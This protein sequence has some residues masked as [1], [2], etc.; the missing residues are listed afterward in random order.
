MFTSIH[1]VAEF[2]V[3]HKDLGRHTYDSFIWKLI[4]CDSKYKF[5]C[6]VPG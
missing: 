6:I 4:N 2:Y 1:R 5:Q 3:V